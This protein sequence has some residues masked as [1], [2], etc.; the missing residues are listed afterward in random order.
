MTY[1]YV[2]DRDGDIYHS[3]GGNPESTWY[4]S[5]DAS[6]NIE[7]IN[8]RYGPLTRLVFGE[9]LE[10]FKPHPAGTLVQVDSDVIPGG[11]WMAGNFTVVDYNSNTEEYRVAFNVHRD[12]VKGQVV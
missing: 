11:G 2:I 4:D 3:V 7:E 8:N 6:V 9:R 5:N 10:I 12:H 1:V